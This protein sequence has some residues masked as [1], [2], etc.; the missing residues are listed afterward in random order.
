MRAALQIRSGLQGAVPQLHATVRARRNQLARET[1]VP[2]DPRDR[3]RAREHDIRREQERPSSRAGRHDGR[4]HGENGRKQNEVR[5]ELRRKPGQQT[6]QRELTQVVRAQRTGEHREAGHEDDRADRI[7][8]LRRRVDRVER[9]QRDEERSSHCRA[10]A[11]FLAYKPVEQHRHET[12]QQHLRDERHPGPIA[13]EAVEEREEVRIAP[14]DVHGGERFAAR[15]PQREI[16][17]VIDS[18]PSERMRRPDEYEDQAEKNRY[19][20]GGVDDPLLLCGRVWNHRRNDHSLS[21][22]ER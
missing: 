2:D 7:G 21:G 12:V 1:V 19:P 3:H 13:R 16:V 15:E 5:T 8:R 6:A 17:V 18:F 14:R 10:A 22:I 4:H 11:E 9:E 20:G